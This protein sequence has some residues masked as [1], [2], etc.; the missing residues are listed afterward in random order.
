MQGRMVPHG[1][2]GFSGVHALLPAALAVLVAACSSDPGPPPR[3]GPAQPLPAPRVVEGPGP[4][5][6]TSGGIDPD[7]PAHGHG[8]LGV[9]LA[10]TGQGEPGVRV[11]SVVRGSPAAQSGL[12]QGDV[13]LRIGGKAVQ[14]PRQVVRTVGGHAAGERVAVAFR[15]AH[16]DRLV[17]VTLATLPDDDTIMRMSYVGAPAPPLTGLKSVQGSLTPRLG[18]LRGK[19]V[20]LEFWAPWCMVCRVMAPTM[21]D[22][23]HRYGAQGVAV[24][25]VTMTPVQQAASA[26]SQIGMSYPI[27]SD[28]SGKVTEAYR[29]TALPTLFVIDRRGIVRDVLVGYSSPRL[30]ELQAEVDR[31]VAER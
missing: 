30:K 15:R 25:G 28:E 16:S 24:M 14:S 31:L 6:P 2:M 9:E 21:N 20:L 8:W 1:S 10:A 7:G 22:W 13:L 18:A 12:Q 26:A 3:L 27:A 4:I 5:T 29:A 11:R 19:V 23:N 17:A